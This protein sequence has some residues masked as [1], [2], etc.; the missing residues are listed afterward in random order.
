MV[1]SSPGPSSNGDC[2]IRNGSPV[3]SV[4]DYSVKRAKTDIAEK[5]K[6][7]RQWIVEIDDDD[8][9]LF[10]RELLN[11][12]DAPNLEYIS[13]LISQLRVSRTRSYSDGNKDPFMLLPAH[14]V[15]R[16]LSYLDPNLFL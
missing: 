10:I 8:K 1:M 11:E 3:S 16:I 13:V 4:N 9:K 6:A 15:L 7:F 2:N 14:I 12:C 5:V